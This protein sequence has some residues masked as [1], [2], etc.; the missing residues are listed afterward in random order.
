[1][2]GGRLKPLNISIAFSAQNK[3]GASLSSSNLHLLIINL[4]LC[5]S[6]IENCVYVILWIRNPRNSFLFNK[7]QSLHNQND[8]RSRNKY[9]FFSCC[10]ALNQKRKDA[11]RLHPYLLAP[12]DGYAPVV[13]LLIFFGYILPA[14]LDIGFEH[15]ASFGTWP[16]AVFIYRFIN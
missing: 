7:Q 3:W 16:P 11:G 2:S 6:A 13:L 10:I 8:L 15:A 9:C 5:D 14:Y 1:M 12:A 4:T